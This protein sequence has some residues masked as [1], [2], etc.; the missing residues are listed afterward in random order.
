MKTIN[1][2]GWLPIS[3]PRK[4]PF[5][6]RPEDF[7][8]CLKE[9]S[10]G[11]YEALPLFCQFIKNV[12]I[13]IKEPG[14]GTLKDLQRLNGKFCFGLS[15]CIF[16]KINCCMEFD[17]TISDE[18][19]GGNYTYTTYDCVCSG[20][21]ELSSIIKDMLI[22]ADLAFPARISADIGR[23]YWGRKK[24]YVISDSHSSFAEVL[25]NV[26]L[27]WPPIRVVPFMKVCKWVNRLGLFD[28]GIA[29]S[30]IQR[31]LSSF[32]H[33]YS[34]L[35][36]GTG[37]NLFWS[38]QGLEAFYCRGNGDLRRQLSEKSRVFLGQW[39]E[40]K[41]IVGNLYDFRS[42][43]IHGSF[44]LERQ[45]SEVMYTAE[46]EKDQDKLY[47]ATMFA[48]RML[49]SSI[50]KCAEENIVSVEFSYSMKIEHG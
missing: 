29:R 3:D 47:E 48:S 8:E 46:D 14:V 25:H 9:F 13:Q 17:E 1:I 33:L 40:T 42:K 5:I 27:K 31:A 18:S 15:N 16:I 34:S 39:E 22:L 11:L 44:N 30:P 4:L 32:T 41:N 36:A 10:S 21:Y 19:N 37:E 23:T 50:Q 35:D 45:N 7:D 2:V 43:F 6:Y 38:M 49:L 12:N 26:N 24:M 28:K 20:A